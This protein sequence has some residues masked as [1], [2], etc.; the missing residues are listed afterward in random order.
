MSGKRVKGAFMKKRYLFGFAAMLLALAL[1][2][3]GCDLFSDLFNG[4][5]DGQTTYTPLVI[6]GKDS[7]GRSVTATF[8][9]PPLA[10]AAIPIIDPLQGD[11]YEIKRDNSVVSSGTIALTGTAI[12]FIATSGPGGSGTYTT[13]GDLAFSLTSGIDGFYVPHLTKVAKPVANPSTNTSIKLPQTV[14]LTAVSGAEIWYTTDNSDPG[15]GKNR[16]TGP[17]AVSYP[18]GNSF[19]IK[20]VAIKGDMAQS[21]FLDELYS[22]NVEAPTAVTSANPVTDNTT[23][24]FSSKTEGAEFRW[25][26]TNNGSTPVDPTY[27][28]GE[29]EGTGGTT[30]GEG[31]VIGI[32][33]GGGGSFNVKVM[34]IKKDFTN[35]IIVPLSYSKQNPNVGDGKDDWFSANEDD[36]AVDEKKKTIDISGTVRAN[37]NIDIKDGYLLTIKK[38]EAE[39]ATPKGG[40]LTVDAGREINIYGTGDFTTKD[41]DGKDKKEKRN[42]TLVVQGD[43]T[44]KV[45]GRIIVGEYGILEVITQG[46]DYPVLEGNG[47]ITVKAGGRMYISL[48]DKNGFKLEKATGQIVVEAGGLLCIVGSDGTKWPLIGTSETKND[49]T[50]KPTIIGADFALQP[51]SSITLFPSTDGTQTPMSLSGNA[52]VYGGPSI[53][54]GEESKDV[55]NTVQ[56][57]STF[58]VLPGASL[59]IGKDDTDKNKTTLNIDDGQLI[60]Q[61]D[62]V[63]RKYA[64]ITGSSQSS[65]TGNVVKDKDGNTIKPASSKD[66]DDKTTWTWSGTP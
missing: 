27:S 17:I 57:T 50:E 7:T 11:S 63:V 60:N 38:V 45:Y 4:D 64:K 10:K 3:A 31:N 25:A 21:E 41:N 66:D 37:R 61:G 54:D 1:M 30:F 65:V 22:N 42:S 2:F 23:I 5:D 43:A 59:T 55:R 62:V 33:F 19:R 46:S 44:L 56:L 48:L 14:T 12:T 26:W 28:G 52:V 40:T 24:T 35:S 49:W 32:D 9:R 20:A 53:T 29:G 8:T 18:N 15:P 13:G 47:T 36:V 16:Y 34:A 39:D 51:G 58:T 6:P